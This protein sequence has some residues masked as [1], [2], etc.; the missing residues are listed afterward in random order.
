M[1][2]LG[3]LRADGVSRYHPRCR[4][5]GGGLCRRQR[6]RIG[7]LGVLCAIIMI[8]VASFQSADANP[9]FD[10][11]GVVQNALA[12]DQEER[13]EVGLQRLLVA[14]KELGLKRV[15]PF[16][17]ALTEASIDR[18]G[19]VGNLLLETAKRLDPLLPAPRFMMGGRAWESGYRVKGLG[20]F[21]SG[22]VNM[23]RLPSVRG[24]LIS[25]AVPWVLMT[26]GLSV[27]AAIVVQVVIFFRLIAVDV[28]G[29]PPLEVARILIVS[30]VVSV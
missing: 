27:A 17:E 13:L 5:V 25:S 28:V 8:L 10:A 21:A 29:P 16:A 4:D 1:G 11:W 3:R 12:T 26:L 15:T 7:R 30:T 19:P 14:K 20:E 9:L 2:S 24:A 22:A 6:V 18:P 23:M